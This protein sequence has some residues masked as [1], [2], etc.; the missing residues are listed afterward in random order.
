[1]SMLFYFQP[2]ISYFIRLDQI[3]AALA[4]Y[5]NRPHLYAYVIKNHEEI[6]DTIQGT[7]DHKLKKRK[8]H[9][10][11]AVAPEHQPAEPPEVLKLRAEMQKV[12]LKSLP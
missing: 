10:P 11:T 5:L 4:Q 7:V 6:L 2:P 9:A 3:K 12:T 1:M 8:R